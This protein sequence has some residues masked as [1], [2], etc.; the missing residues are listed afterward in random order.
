MSNSVEMIEILNF[1][2][3]VGDKSVVCSAYRVHLGALAANETDTM[4]FSR[5]R[6]CP[7]ANWDS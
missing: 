7:F 5:E 1:P 6:F 3:P 4:W 2:D